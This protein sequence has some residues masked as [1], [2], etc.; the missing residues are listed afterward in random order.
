MDQNYNFRN[1]LHKNCSVKLRLGFFVLIC[2]STIACKTTMDSSLQNRIASS[3][4]TA[5]SCVFEFDLLEPSITNEPYSTDLPKTI[6]STDWQI[7]IRAGYLSRLAY[8]TPSDI[9]KLL[10]KAGFKH[11]SVI[12]DK[13]MMAIVASRSKCTYVA[14]RG[15]DM[16]SLNDWMVDATSSSRRV[17]SGKIHKGFYRAYQGLHKKISH[18]LKK[19]H[20]P[21]NSLII[22]GHSLGGALAGIYGYYNDM[23]RFLDRKG[24]PISSVITFGQPLFADLNLA[25]KL[26]REFNGRYFRFVNDRD[27]VTRVPPWFVHFGALVWLK[28][29]KIDFPGQRLVYGSTSSAKDE[30]PAIPNELEPSKEAYDEFLNQT[31][32]QP[33][34]SSGNIEQEQPVGSAI[35]DHS[36]KFYLSRMIDA[37]Y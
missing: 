26:N 18:I 28:E 6:S 23:D 11:S 16:T 12:V 37:R 4:E 36:M 32:T 7:M 25:I 2:I 15:T 35:G 29:L 22:T 20:R 27:I 30:L 17:P 19:T 13:N 1:S 24:F 8:E 31:K 9:K 3:A 33:F 5:D 10:S 34:G 14:F 21:E